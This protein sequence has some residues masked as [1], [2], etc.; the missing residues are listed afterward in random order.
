[1]SISSE[2]G[3]NFRKSGCECDTGPWLSSLVTEMDKQVHCYIDWKGVLI[4]I[5]LLLPLGKGHCVQKRYLVQNLWR[6]AT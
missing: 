6:L 4:T 3:V 2:Q 5:R 1:M